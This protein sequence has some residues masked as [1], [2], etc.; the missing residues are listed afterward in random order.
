[1]KPIFCFLDSILEPRTPSPSELAQLRVLD[2]RQQTSSPPRYQVW[3]I[4]VLCLWSEVAFLY[5]FIPT[6]KHAEPTQMYT[7]MKIFACMKIRLMEFNE[8]LSIVIT[9][10]LKTIVPGVH[11]CWR[12]RS[13]VGDSVLRLLP[14]HSPEF[15]EQPCWE[16]LCNEPWMMDCSA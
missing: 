12:T 2:L 4:P 16:N 9:W 14:P 13:R 6:V 5:F 8:M 11:V 3:Y 15:P 10:E 7:W 1:M